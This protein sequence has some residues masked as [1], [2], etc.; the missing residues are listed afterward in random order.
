MLVYHWKV[1]TLI[2]LKDASIKIMASSTALESEIQIYGEV[3]LDVL[4]HYVLYIFVSYI[5]K[6]YMNNT[7]HCYNGWHWIAYSSRK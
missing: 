5:N 2:D 4:K 6:K 7:L 3:V 1:K